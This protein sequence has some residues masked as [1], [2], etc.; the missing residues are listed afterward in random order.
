MLKAIVIG[1]LAFSGNTQYTGPSSKTSEC[2]TKQD[3]CMTIKD[4]Y[5]AHA[6]NFLTGVYHIN[7]VPLNEHSHAEIWLNAMGASTVEKISLTGKS[8]YCA[9]QFIECENNNK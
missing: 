8:I 6:R 1:L 2:L 4:S 3:E 5:A 9:K 7:C